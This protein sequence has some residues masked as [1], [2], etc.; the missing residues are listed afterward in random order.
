[1]KKTI[2][3]LLAALCITG[4]VGCSSNKN[5]VSQK[6]KN[7][8]LAANA[9]NTAKTKTVLDPLNATYKIDNNLIKL[10][11]GKSVV[12]VAPGSASKLVTTVWKQAAIADLNGDKINDAALILIQDGG[13]SGTFYYVAAN[14]S[15]KDGKHIGTN[16]I[17]LGD[18]IKMQSI[19]IEN[20]NIVV[21]Y[22]DRKENDPMTTEPSV[23]KTRTFFISETSLVE[24]TK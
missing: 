15:L 5:Q 21:N 23:A 13:G 12:E 2:S 18:R 7:V 14:I 4:V 20:G 10:T 19:K 22:L 6:T 9:A 1:M 8:T 24:K 16:A 3:I 11:N 17:L